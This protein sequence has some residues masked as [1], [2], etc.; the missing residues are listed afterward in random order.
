MK[1]SFRFPTF[2]RNHR[3][4][5]PLLTFSH[6]LVRSSSS[7]HGP[8][9]HT[10]RKRKPEKRKKWINQVAAVLLRLTNDL[11]APGT[12]ETASCP[13][14]SSLTFWSG[15]A[16]SASF[17]YLPKASCFCYS[18]TKK[19]FIHQTNRISIGHCRYARKA[20]MGIRNKPLAGPRS[21][22]DVKTGAA[23]YGA[24]RR[25]PLAKENVLYS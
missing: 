19:D 6:S 18:R 12:G 4:R 15:L 1:S 24:V 21:H 10:V 23:R 9:F 13:L 8:K 20:E 3:S 22:E 5:V 16:V 17:P 7:N 11:R 14:V 2:N 25:F